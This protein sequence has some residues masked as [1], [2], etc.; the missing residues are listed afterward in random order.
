MNK[1]RNFS[2]L[3]IDDEAWDQY[4]SPNE[5]G[6][7]E[8]NMLM[9][10]LERAILDYVGNERRE[11]EDA[12]QWIFNHTLEDKGRACSFPWICNELD[13]DPKY[14]MDTIAA[15][16]KRGSHRTAPWYFTKTEA[17]KQ[18]EVLLKNPALSKSIYSQKQNKRQKKFRYDSNNLNEQNHCHV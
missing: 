8:R 15:M 3:E 4:E 12:A 17:A 2:T 18:N 5:Q 11:V 16:P 9:A 6:T 14:V 7:P 13:L 10:V 1:N